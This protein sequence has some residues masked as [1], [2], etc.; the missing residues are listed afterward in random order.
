MLILKQ[1]QLIITFEMLQNI[2]PIHDGF[3]VE[4]QDLFIKV[5]LW[6][7]EVIEP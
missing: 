5:L 7:T 4:K 6:V 3:R 2:L 1:I